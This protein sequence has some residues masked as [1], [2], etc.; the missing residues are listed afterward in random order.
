MA[1]EIVPKPKVKEIPWLKIALSLF[2]ALLLIA[3]LSY[4]ALFFYQ[5][6]LSK[7]LALLENQLERTEEEEELERRVLLYQQK[8]A[9]YGILLAEHQL[10]Y[11]LPLKI[12]EFLEKNTHPDIWFSEFNLDSENNIVRVSGYTNN[13]ETL[14]QQMFILQKQETLKSIDL[15]N[16]S[17]NREKGIEFEFTLIFDPKI[18]K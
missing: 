16:V 2:V 1:I 8:I 14:S 12:F 7:E 15:S 11:Q 4:L 3:L 17:I 5:N 18:I 6:R 10:K 9:D 13:F